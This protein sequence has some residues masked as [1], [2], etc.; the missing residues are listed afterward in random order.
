M[1]VEWEVWLTDGR[2]FS[3]HDTDWSELP[4]GVLVVKA[5]FD[6]HMA[7]N[8]GDGVYGH[9]ATWKQAG[10]VSDAAFEAALSEAQREELSPSQRYGNGNS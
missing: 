2:R 4:D 3:S 1:S 8:W 6:G 5:W 9:P 7:V 10:W